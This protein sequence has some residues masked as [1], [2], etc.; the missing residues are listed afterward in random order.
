MA[1][2]KKSIDSAAQAQ[3]IAGDAC[4]LHDDYRRMIQAQRTELRNIL[5]AAYQAVT[6]LL[7]SRQ[8]WVAFVESDIWDETGVHRPAVAGQEQAQLHFMRLVLKAVPDAK[9]ARDKAGKFAR[10][11]DALRKQ[12]CR[13]ERVARQLKKQSI[14]KLARSVAKERSKRKAAAKASEDGDIIEQSEDIE[15]LSL[16]DIDEVDIFADDE[17]SPDVDEVAGDSNELRF[18]PVDASDRMLERLWTTFGEIIQ[19]KAKIIRKDGVCRLWIR[20]VKPWPE[21]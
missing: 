4:R 20:S 8:T 12:D 6:P 14:E 18:M 13:P 2:S 21:D 9:V 3:A 5:Q 16:P 11:L 17:L 15:L 10:A 1:K 7:R 19:V